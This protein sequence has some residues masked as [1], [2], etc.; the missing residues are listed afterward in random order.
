M[1]GEAGFE[2][3]RD[4]D[5]EEEYVGGDVEDRIDNL[6][7]LVGRALGFAVLVQGTS[8]CGG[9]LTIIR[10]HSPVLLDGSADGKKSQLVAQEGYHNPDDEPVEEFALRGT[11]TGE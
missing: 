1:Y 6:V 2:N 9:T 4:A 3:G 10:R 8:I 5:S 11:I 7:I